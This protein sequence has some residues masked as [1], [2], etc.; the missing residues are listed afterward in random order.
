MAGGWWPPPYAAAQKLGHPAGASPA[1]AQASIPGMVPGLIACIYQRDEPFI[2]LCQRCHR[3]RVAYVEA[4]I[5]G[6]NIEQ[7]SLHLRD[8]LHSTSND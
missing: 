5:S 7:N 1:A 8:L 3:V 4:A 6:L 2:D